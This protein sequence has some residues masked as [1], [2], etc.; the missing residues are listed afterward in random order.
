MPACKPLD[1]NLAEDLDAEEELLPMIFA[2]ALP[3]PGQEL[4]ESVQAR[5]AV[6]RK[7]DLMESFIVSIQ[8]KAL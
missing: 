4:R 1:N 7:N 5:A 2:A 6:Q 8:P 3:P